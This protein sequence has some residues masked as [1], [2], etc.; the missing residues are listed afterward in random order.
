MNRN[1][2]FTSLLPSPHDGLLI[3]EEATG[4][5]ETGQ[6]ESSLVFV[7]SVVFLCLLIGGAI[8]RLSTSTARSNE[9]KT[10]PHSVLSCSP[11][12][13]YES[14][15][16]A[17]QALL[18]AKSVHVNE[19]AILWRQEKRIL[20]A[21]IDQLAQLQPQQPSCRVQVVQKKEEEKKTDPMDHPPSTS[22]STAR[23]QALQDQVRA[24]T[25]LTQQQAQQLASRNNQIDKLQNIMEEIQ[26]NMH[27]TKDNSYNPWD[28]CGMDTDDDDDEDMDGTSHDQLVQRLLG[29]IAKQPTHV[30]EELE[31]QLC[32]R[33]QSLSQQNSTVSTTPSTI[34]QHTDDTID[35]SD[36]SSVESTSDVR[37]EASSDDDDE[38]DDD[39]TNT[40]INDNKV[41]LLFSTMPGNLQVKMQQSRLEAIFRHGLQLA[42]DCLELLDACQPELEQLRNDLFRIS[43]LH[44]VYPQVFLVVGG[45]DI[46]FLGDYETVLEWHDARQLPQRIGLVL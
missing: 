19:Q 30:Q 11:Q 21:R 40:L 35:D 13:E 32:Q 7:S 15:I 31:L 8:W 39:D 46:Q 27:P 20:E 24:L 6:E 12:E 5:V 34:V 1:S 36:A 25:T 22:S 41:V 17:L 33:R 4:R 37:S 23:I 2:F 42:P 9:E 16:A 43:G 29:K 10:K 3:R 26:Q 44:A 38:L 18:Q 14:L 45:T 28:T